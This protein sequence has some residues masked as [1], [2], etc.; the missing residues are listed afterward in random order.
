M[1]SMDTARRI[2]SVLGI[3][4]RIGHFFFA[5]EVPHGLAIVRIVLPLVLLIV[6]LQR[7]PHARE[8]YST[9]GAAAPLAINYGFPNLTPVPPAFVAV[10]MI[11]ALAFFLV[12]SSIG[13]FTR[14]SL[15]ASTVLYTYLNLLDCVSTMTKYSVLASHGLLLLCFSN[16]GAIWSIDGRRMRTGRRAA[17]PL[18][19][20][21]R[22]KSPVWPQRLM[23]FLIG[24]LY[25][26]S[27]ITKIHTPGFLSG[28]QLRFWMMT[29]ANFSNPVGE[30]LTL[31][32]ALLVVFAY[33]AVVWETLFLFLVWRG[34]GRIFMLAMG[35]VFHIM[36]TLTLGL[37]I[38]PMV[39]LSLYFCF[40]NEEDAHRFARLWRLIQ[41]KLG[42]TGQRSPI[43]RPWTSALRIPLAWRFPAAAVFGFAVVLTMLVGIEAEYWLDPY[44][45]R[46]PEGPH[47]LVELDP[48]LVRQ[49]LGPERRIRNQDKLLE[50]VVGTE[51]F[52]GVVIGRRTEF[53]QGERLLAQCALNPPHED[54]VVECNLHDADDRVLDR[55]GQI[56]S[57]SMMR[58]NFVY[59]M[60]EAL[61]PG[62][63]FLV[64]RIAGQEVDRRL[65]TLHR[66]VDSPVAN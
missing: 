43:A 17:W 37:Y 11:T 30:Y 14:F 57:R 10:A 23:Q 59:N 12:T 13:W 56:V 5:E 25:F 55:V 44:G 4:S 61:Q 65:I 3:K 53:R 8:L 50:F 46:R 63:Y 32:P 42:W 38:F 34:W 27:A 28:D 51:M 62:R 64:L 41:V 45:K 1:L 66:N 6:V 20:M 29:N 19:D 15:I 36:T 58:C 9:D 21:S 16:C 22:A 33:I 24:A 31:F 26:G 35:V 39:T 7:W 60:T 18:D 2:S 40:L 49:M 54:M 47:P 48:A 52:G